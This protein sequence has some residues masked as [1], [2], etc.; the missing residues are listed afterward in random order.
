MAVRRANHYTKQVVLKLLYMSWN[1]KREIFNVLLQNLMHMEHFEICI[2][3]LIKNNIFQTSIAMQFKFNALYFQG[4][5]QA[6]A[7]M[8]SMWPHDDVAQRNPQCTWRNV[9]I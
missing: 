6:S 9:K 1:F 4:L 7:I 3:K 8:Y 5:D 2:L